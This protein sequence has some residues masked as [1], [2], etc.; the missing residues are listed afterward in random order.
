MSLYPSTPHNFGL[1]P[2]KKTL[3]KQEQIQIPIEDLLQM[4]EFVLEHIF[5][6]F[7]NHIKQ[8]ISWKTISTKCGP[9][10]ACILMDKVKTEF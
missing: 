6:E 3:D 4:V 1:R 7:S 2:L 8:Q 10:Y 5:F 9:M